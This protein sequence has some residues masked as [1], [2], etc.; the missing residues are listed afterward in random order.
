MLMLKAHHG[1]FDTSFDDLLR[2]LADTY[3]E[4]NKGTRQYLLGEEA[5]PASGD[6]A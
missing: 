4:G 5:D 3:P 1:W 6:E 2:I